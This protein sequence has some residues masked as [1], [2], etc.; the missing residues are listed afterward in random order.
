MPPLCTRS[1]GKLTHHGKTQQQRPQPTFKGQKRTNQD[2]TS[3]NWNNKS[4]AKTW[5]PQPWMRKLTQAPCKT[6]TD[7]SVAKKRSKHTW[8]PRVSKRLWMQPRLPKPKQRKSSLPCK[9][10][11]QCSNRVDE[12]ELWERKESWPTFLPLD[13]TKPATRKWDQARRTGKFHP[14]SEGEM[15]LADKFPGLKS[16]IAAMSQQPAFLEA[17]GVDTKAPDFDLPKAI[18]AFEMHHI[19]HSMVALIVS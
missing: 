13:K 16:V 11:H 10:R 12:T 15:N 6:P 1:P 2:C 7:S 17:C 14:L 5:K 19:P 8:S 4:A 3:Q 18:R 9:Q